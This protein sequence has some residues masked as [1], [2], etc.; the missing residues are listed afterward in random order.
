ML[1]IRK[2]IEEMKLTISVLG[3]YSF[4]FNNVFEHTSYF[5]E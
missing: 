3:K 2:A 5:Q 4:R 1:R